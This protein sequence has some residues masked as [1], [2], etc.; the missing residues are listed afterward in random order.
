MSGLAVFSP[1]EGER[2]LARAL[3]ARL[4]SVHY[5]QIMGANLATVF[6]ERNE[7]RRP[8]AI[9]EL[10]CADAV[11]HAPHASAR[12]HDAISAAIGRLLAKL[13]SDFTFTPDGLAVG[14]NGAGWINWRFG[15]KQAPPL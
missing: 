12:G 9:G 7:V 8:K 11:L 15:P 10:Y 14:H 3:R 4:D 2:Q 5:D 6:S 1:D 13:P